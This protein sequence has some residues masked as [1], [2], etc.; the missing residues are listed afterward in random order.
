M[1]ITLSKTQQDI[2]KEARRFLKKECPTGLLREM[3][4]DERGYPSRLWEKMADLGWMGVMIPE[5]YGGIGGNL[6]DLAILLEAMGEVNC[7]GPF[8]STVV[9]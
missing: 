7:P 9:M 3:K 1:D 4:D 5:A 6:L 8:F 2:T